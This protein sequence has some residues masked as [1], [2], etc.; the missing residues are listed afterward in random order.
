MIEVAGDR[1]RLA[2]VE[3]SDGACVTHALS[4]PGGVQGLADS[5]FQLRR[6]RWS[7]KLLA[8]TLSPPKAGADSFL[9]DAAL[10]LSKHAQHLKHR[11]SGRRRG[12]EALLMQEPSALSCRDEC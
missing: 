4:T 7:A 8:L 9:D 6:Y 1:L 5:L 12:V 2:A 10:E 11:F 3:L